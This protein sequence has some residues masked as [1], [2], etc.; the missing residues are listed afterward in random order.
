MGG[1]EGRGDTPEAAAQRRDK[2]FIARERSKVVVSLAVVAADL[3][4]SYV[5]SMVSRA[6]S[7]VC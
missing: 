6:L 4:G 2:G 3:R 7:Y 1:K 5:V